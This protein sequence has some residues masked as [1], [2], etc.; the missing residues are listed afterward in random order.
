MGFTPVPIDCDPKTLNVMS[1]NLLE[2]LEQK[3]V[4][5][6]AFFAT[7]VLGFAG[8]LDQIRDIC[9][10]EKILFFEDNCEA[11][12]TRLADRLTGSFSLASSFSFFVA[13][14]MSTIEGGLVCTDNEE[15]ADMLTIVRANGWDRNLTAEKQHKWREHY[16]INS[17]FNAKYTFYDLAYNLRPTEITGFLGCN[18]M[19]H[20]EKNISTRE[21]NYIFLEENVRINPD[22]ISQDKYHIEKLSSFAFPVITKTRE[23]HDLYLA[24]FSG[25]GVE[26]RP[27]I[28]GNIQSQPFYK[29]YTKKEYELPGT[30][31]LH[32]CS[33][34]CGNYPELTNSELDVLRSCLLKH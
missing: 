31:F 20:L 10:E 29:K 22:L 2:R 28:A 5:L 33:F 17:E 19:Q 27:M 9:R 6:K 8:D 4:N 23:L 15:F 18:Q 7:N 14:H 16:N 11:L 13:H 26:V 25:A 3:D 32:E 24:K 30:E 12:G 1:K 34:Y 21:S